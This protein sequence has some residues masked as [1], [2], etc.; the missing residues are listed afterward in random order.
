MN[1]VRIHLTSYPI[2]TSYPAFFK[3]A[4]GVRS[5]HPGILSRPVQCPMFSSVSTSSG[6][7]RLFSA[8]A[9]AIETCLKRKLSAQAIG[10]DGDDLR[11]LVNDLWT[12]HDNFDDGGDTGR[13]ADDAAN[14]FGEDEE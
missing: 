7:A 5:Y 6:T 2:P 3:A 1:P 10:I 12:L 13:A 8:Y 11:D 14:V 9:T 4:D